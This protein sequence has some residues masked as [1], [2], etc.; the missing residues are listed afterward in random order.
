MNLLS[1]V[2][3]FHTN[4][5]RNVMK[6]SGARIGS[7]WAKIG[8]PG[9][10]IGGSWAKVGALGPRLRSP[11]RPGLGALVPI[12]RHMGPRLVALGSRMG[13]MGPRLEALGQ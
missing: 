1:F 12:L 11:L 9:A 3:N 2:H 13:V 6:A 8:V 5:A 10:K 7:S 4:K